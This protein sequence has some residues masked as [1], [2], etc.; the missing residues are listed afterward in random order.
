MVRKTV[1]DKINS[2]AM[3]SNPFLFIRAL[4][5]YIVLASQQYC[6]LYTLPEVTARIISQQEDC[7]E[8]IHE[9]GI[10]AFL[11]ADYRK[12][13]EILRGGCDNE[14]PEEYQSM[15]RYV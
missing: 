8:F 5:S 3:V 9:I 13:L 12:G 1:H 2:D 15:R 4:D 7:A 10:P 6:Y 11:L 14:I